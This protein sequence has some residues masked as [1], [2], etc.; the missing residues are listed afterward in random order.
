VAGMH[1]SQGRVT[2]PGFYDQVRPLDEKERAELARLPVD[3]PFYL[4][5][6]GVPALYG[7]AGYS[8]IERVGARPTLE[9]NGMLSG[10]TG[11]GSKTVLPAKAM[12]K[13]SMRLVPDQDPEAVRQQ[14]L[15]YL[16]AK[17]PPTVCWELDQ[18]AGGKASVTDITIPGVLALSKALEATW[19]KRP[20]FRRE[21]GSVPV[22]AQMHT[23]L[24]IE[25]VLTGFGL[26][27][28]NLHA[29]NEKIHL[30]TFFRGIDAVIR[31][32]S[33]LGQ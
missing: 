2:L 12:A 22:V 1:D 10:F 15:A 25:S 6:T 18:F 19:G 9:V 13:I 14:L 5:Q 26:P 33:I 27:D 31:Y 21:G 30:P 8:S 3:D 23:I 16:Q 32:L 4:E 17:A 28:D 11:E 24:G 20:V 29:P 7:E